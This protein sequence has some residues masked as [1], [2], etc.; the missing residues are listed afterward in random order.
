MS[1]KPVK[2]KKYYSLLI[3]CNSLGDDQLPAQRASWRIPWLACFVNFPLNSKN[4][5]Q[6]GRAEVA[7]LTTGIEEMLYKL[8]RSTELRVGPK[9]PRAL[10]R[11]WQSCLTMISDK[12]RSCSVAI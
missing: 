2:H 4:L 9:A 7:A 3:D 1:H 12:L 10:C 11:E 6:K 5:L 8:G